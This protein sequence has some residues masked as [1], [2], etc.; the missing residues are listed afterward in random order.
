MWYPS[1]ELLVA[2]EL[3]KFSLHASTGFNGRADE[4]HVNTRMCMCQFKDKSPRQ[5]W[6][7]KQSPRLS[8]AA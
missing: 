7:T 5:R 6:K 2:S 1:F 3:S 4:C 8:F